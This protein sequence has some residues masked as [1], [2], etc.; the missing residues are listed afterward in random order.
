MTR[1]RIIDKIRRHVISNP[2]SVIFTLCLVVFIF[3]LSSLVLFVDQN[4]L[5]NPDEF[6]WN[7]F[8]SNLA[9]LDFCFKL[10]QTLK[11]EKE[12]MV[13][14]DKLVLDKFMIFFC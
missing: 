2:P 13:F 11:T 6:D 9:D 10:P 12:D 1:I 4:Q 3:V 14:Q 7:A 8:E 5:R